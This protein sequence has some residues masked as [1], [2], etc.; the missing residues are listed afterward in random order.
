[1]NKCDIKLGDKLVHIISSENCS[2][3]WVAFDLTTPGQDT[4]YPYNNEC[5]WAI[6][7]SGRKYIVR[8]S[9]LRKASKLEKALK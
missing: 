7:P 1:M 2:G 5:F 8:A 9:E 3:I 4:K 6:G